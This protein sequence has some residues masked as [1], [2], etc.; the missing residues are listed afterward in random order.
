MP[1]A[2]SKQNSNKRQVEEH[3]DIG[4][5]PNH[6]FRPKDVSQ[7]ALALNRNKWLKRQLTNLDQHFDVPPP[8]LQSQ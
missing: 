3:G 4:S 1:H 5:K 7:R 6:Y 8:F 2:V